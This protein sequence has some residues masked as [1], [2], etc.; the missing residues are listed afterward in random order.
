MITALLLLIIHLFQIKKGVLPL[1]FAVPFIRNFKYFNEKI[2]LNINYKPQLKELEEFIINYPK[3]RINIF[4][5]QE[6]VKNE[7]NLIIIKALYDKYPHIVAV[8]PYYSDYLEQ[9]ATH[10]DLPYFYDCAITNWDLFN[11][12][13]KLNVTDILLQGEILFSLDLLKEKIKNTDIHLRCFC[14]LSSFSDW[15]KGD[16]SIKSFFIRPEDIDF[17]SKYIDT[18]DFYFK[19]HEDILQKLNI[20]YEIYAQEK[21]WQGKLKEL[22]I[23]YIGEE[24]NRFITPIFAERRVKCEK[25][26]EKDPSCSCNLCENIYD[27]GKL[28]SKII[29]DHLKK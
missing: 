10:N 17:Y 2:Q 26:C 20:F 18:F 28:R 14:N 5:S 7:K 23:N 12:I 8:F 21:K 6:D 22:I 1:N 29:K 16:N 27:M 3:N 15:A 11:T 24:D 25:R 4:L 19:S 13:V 9:W